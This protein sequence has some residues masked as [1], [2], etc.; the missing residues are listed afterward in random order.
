VGLE[1]LTEMSMKMITLTMEAESVSETSV[2]FYQGTKR[3]IPEDG[4]LQNDRCLL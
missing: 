3:N 4:Q 2:N 1:I